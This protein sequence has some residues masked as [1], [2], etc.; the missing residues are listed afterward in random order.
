MLGAVDLDLRLMEWVAHHRST[1]ATDVAWV[2]MAC[3]SHRVLALTMVAVFLIGLA[4]GQSG[5]IWVSMAAGGTG[6]VVAT[7]LK[8]LVD[9]PRPPA[10]LA[11]VVTGTSS[12][13]STV[14]AL[15]AGTAVAL[16]L[17]PHW[18]TRAV[19]RAAALTLTFVVLLVG[20]ALVYLGAHWPTD[21][22]AGWALGAA[23]GVAFATA[24][25]RWTS[26]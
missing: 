11:L 17:A 8:T 6:S 15:T 9:R 21:V 13:P 16:V 1:G 4:V 20:W 5:A 3:S 26:R 18:P 10:D 2:L 19:R 24:Y 25:A 7:A 12:M 14:A 23:F 22:L